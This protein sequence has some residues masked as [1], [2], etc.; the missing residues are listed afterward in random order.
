MQK[1]AKIEG[2]ATLPADTF[3]LGP[4]SGSELGKE[5]NGRRL[6]FE[7]QPVQGFSSLLEADGTDN[8]YWVITDNG[9][10]TK[11]ISADFLLRMYRIR[12]EFGSG[13][14]GSGNV[15]VEE[16][17]RLRDPERHIPFRI[18]NEYTKDRLLTGADFDPESVQRDRAGDLWFGDEYGPFLLH[19]DATG[20][21]LDAPFP[22]P[23]VR[24]PQNSYSLSP[25]V[26]NLPAS[27]GFEGMAISEDG[28]FLYP[29]LGG[30]LT[31]DLDQRRR[32]IYEFDLQRKRYTGERWQYHA[33]KPE[34][35]VSDL[36][37]VTGDSRN[38]LLLVERTT[39]ETKGPQ[40]VR[41]YLVDLHKVDDSGFLIKRRVLELPE[42][43]VES[44]I[45]ID[46]RK[47]LVITDNDYPFTTNDTQAIVVR[48][49]GRL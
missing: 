42:P 31:Y 7:D 45:L 23:D 32:F 39:A 6:P 22:Q 9:F 17:I 27:Q 40:F 26:A 44:I 21:V 25:R 1:F 29:A 20:Q 10:G 8:T 46:D 2:R 38:R 24:S 16:Y 33:D 5:I 11:A 43:Q 18:T 12:A 13:R 47:I 48:L 14:G 35:T 49:E 28:K 34:N 15:S 36:S 41:V 4:P 30:A 3:T 19:T 37:S